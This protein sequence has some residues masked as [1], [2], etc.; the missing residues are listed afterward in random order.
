MHQL[1]YY[2]QNKATDWQVIDVR[3]ENVFYKE[4]PGPNP[5]S[6]RGHIK[7]SIN[8]PFT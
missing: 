1:A 8:L 5:A 6:I 7:G 4:G 2:L 3:Q